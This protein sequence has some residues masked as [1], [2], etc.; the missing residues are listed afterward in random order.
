M[1][2]RKRKDYTQE[3]F[4]NFMHKSQTK[5]YGYM[6]CGATILTTDPKLYQKLKDLDESMH[7]KD[8]CYAY[9]LEEVGF[10]I[11]K[12]SQIVKDIKHG[13][14]FSSEKVIDGTSEKSIGGECTY[15]FALD[16]KAFDRFIELIPILINHHVEECGIDT[17]KYNIRVPAVHID[18][19]V[20]NK[21]TKLQFGGTYLCSHEF[22]YA[23]TLLLAEMD[24][25]KSTAA[26]SNTAEP[27]QE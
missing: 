9:S 3:L 8:R 20:N 11:T 24:R 23:T 17:E 27:T 18:L 14:L 7:M 1:F 13:L 6:C 10:D 25:L 16:H 21:P 5:P 22:K 4:E 12:D 15:I 19:S 2:E 26:Q